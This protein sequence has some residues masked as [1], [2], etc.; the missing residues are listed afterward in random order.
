[1][2]G[3]GTALADDP[4][5]TCRVTG[6]EHRSPVRVVLDRRLRLWPGSKL[7]RSAREVPV[8]V[9]TGPAPDE[10]AAEAL[11]ALGCEVLRVPEAGDGEAGMPRVLAAL[12][13]RG[14]TRLLVEGGA[15]VAAALLRAH[16][17]DRLHLFTAP[18]VLGAESLPSVG[19]LGLDRLADAPRWRRVEGRALGDDRLDVLDA[20][21]P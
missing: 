13:G 6:L 14:I 1:V 15:G 20:A 8:W 2:V 5:L 12:A 16:L 9:V 19:Q 7:A 10:A 11:G 21:T 18:L 3:S 17:V 4:L